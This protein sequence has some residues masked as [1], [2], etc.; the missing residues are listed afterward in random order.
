MY[1]N[2]A[3]ELFMKTGSIEEYLLYK[4]LVGTQAAEEQKQWWAYGVDKSEWSRVEAD[5][6]G[7]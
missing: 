3:W 2:V 6:G 1:E 7:G 5:G 4:E